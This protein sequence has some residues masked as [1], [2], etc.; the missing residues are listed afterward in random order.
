MKKEDLLE[1]AV[2]CSKALAISG[3][4]LIMTSLST[5]IFSFLALIALATHATNGSPRTE[6]ATF[7]IHCLGSLRTSFQTGK[8]GWH[9]G[10]PDR[11]RVM[12]SM[13]RPSYC[14]T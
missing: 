8:Y 14:G 3:S 7:T 5:A 10:M 1:T 4:T 11:W 12:L 13:V 2:D 9:S 6:A